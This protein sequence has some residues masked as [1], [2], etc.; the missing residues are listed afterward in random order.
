VRLLDDAL[1]EEV[2]Q[3]HV[4]LDQVVAEVRGA[5]QLQRELRATVLDSAIRVASTARILDRVEMRSPDDYYY[6]SYGRLRNFPIVRVRLADAEATALYVDPA[7]GEIVMKEVTRSRAER[8]LYTGLHDLDFRGLSTRR[9]LWDI[10]II[11]LLLGGLSLA[12][13][14]VAGAWRWLAPKAGIKAGPRR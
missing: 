2:R 3:P 4:R 13:T 7:L 9:P 10:V 11:G 5:L 6:P 14:S 12:V 8:W 1:L